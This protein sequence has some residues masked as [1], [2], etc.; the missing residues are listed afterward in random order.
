MFFKKSVKQKVLDLAKFDLD[1]FLFGD[2]QLFLYDYVTSESSQ[3]LIKNMIAM[4][5]LN[6]KTPIILWIN[7]GGG[8]ITDGYA[9]INAIKYIS[10]PVVTI[11]N[12]RACSMAALIS[13]HGYKRFI[14]L[15]SVWMAHDGQAFMCDYFQKLKDRMKFIERLEYINN[16]ILATKTKLSG[17][18]IKQATNGELWLF[19]EECV[20]KGIVDEV[21]KV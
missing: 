17:D 4:D 20:V 16:K 1:K 12:G 14:T 2:R 10:S 19:D 13:V 21:L 8:S 18:E 7:S 9:I 3:R 11:I 15:D 6:P 5:K